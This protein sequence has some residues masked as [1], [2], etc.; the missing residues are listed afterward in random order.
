MIE[1]PIIPTTED[2]EIDNITTDN[3][4]PYEEQKNLLLQR[5]IMDRLQK[6]RI[7]ER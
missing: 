2:Q 6:I 7:L 3:T 4:N 1:K 5:E